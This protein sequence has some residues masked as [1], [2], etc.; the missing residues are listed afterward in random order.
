MRSSGSRFE[1]G[2]YRAAIVRSIA[3]GFPQ[4]AVILYRID[5]TKHM[6]LYYR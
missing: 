1:F 5:S 3:L 4:N 6:H 2:E